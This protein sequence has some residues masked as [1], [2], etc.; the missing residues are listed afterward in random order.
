MMWASYLFFLFFFSSL[1]NVSVLTPR[2]ADAGV[3]PTAERARLPAQRALRR[4][5]KK[6]ERGRGCGRRD[7][8]RRREQR[9]PQ[10]LPIRS[11]GG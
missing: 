4:A 3:R 7:R 9:A 1:L 11:H 6:L 2:Q 8:P 10:P 5:G